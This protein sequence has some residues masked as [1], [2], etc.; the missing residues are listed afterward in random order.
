MTPAVMILRVWAM[1]SGSK[2][3]LG[4]LLTFYVLEMISFTINSII[5]SIKSTGM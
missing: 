4:V 3:I 1:Y 2:I 5:V